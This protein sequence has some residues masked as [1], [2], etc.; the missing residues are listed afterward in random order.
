MGLPIL[1]NKTLMC[2]VIF[3]GIK[4]CSETETGIDFT[5]NSRGSSN[6]QQEFIENN[7]KHRKD[8]FELL[9]SKDKVFSWRP[10]LYV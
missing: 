5:I 2:C 10:N 3:K 7:L 4:F 8:V 6:N 1:S 9:T